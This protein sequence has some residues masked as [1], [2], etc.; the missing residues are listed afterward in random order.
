MFRWPIGGLGGVGG[1]A[2]MAVVVFTGMW[3]LQW[4]CRDE[5]IEAV[6]ARLPQVV[7][8]GLLASLLLAIILERGAEHTFIYFQF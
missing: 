7:R 6:V 1:A 2:V 8:V 3:L 5:R 4:R